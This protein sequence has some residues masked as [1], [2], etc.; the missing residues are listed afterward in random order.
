MDKYHQEILKTIKTEAKIN[1]SHQSHNPQNYEGHNDFVYHLNNPSMRKI[2]KKWV[3]KHTGLSLGKLINLLNSLY[4][5]ESS[6]EKFIASTLLGYLPKLRKKIPLQFIDEW[7]NNL[8]GWCQVDSL[9]QSNFSADDLLL[10][11]PQWKNL[12]IKLSK[13]DNINK[14]RASLVLLVKPVRNSQD[15]RFI[16]IAFQNIDR[17]KTENNILITKA[18]SW[19]LREMIKKHRDLVKEY[20]EKN[21]DKLPKVA[22]RETK[23]K[24]LTGRK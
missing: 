24:L 2:S 7:L 16:K 19:L 4:Q 20:L 8:H 3:K 18:I 11:W 9:C 10:N 6:N 21:L 5:G 12:L 15:S 1:S 22:I 23:N 13:D 17:L 14:R